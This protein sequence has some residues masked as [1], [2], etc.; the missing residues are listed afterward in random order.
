MIHQLHYLGKLQPPCSLMATIFRLTL[1]NQMTKGNAFIIPLDGLWWW[2]LRIHVGISTST[3]LDSTVIERTPLRASFHWVAATPT[4]ESPVAF[5][6]H[7]IRKLKV[8]L[9]VQ[10]AHLG[11]LKCKTGTAEVNIWRSNFLSWRCSL[12]KEKCPKH[13]KT[14]LDNS[15]LSVLNPVCTETR[16]RVLVF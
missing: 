12:S 2:H 16:V 6:W 15:V 7:G 4:L 1:F 11:K 10:L 3:Q 5:H 8:Q 9:A 14:L 13:C